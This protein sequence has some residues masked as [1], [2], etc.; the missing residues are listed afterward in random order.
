[1]RLH[2]TIGTGPNASCARYENTEYRSLSTRIVQSRVNEWTQDILWHIFFCRCAENSDV[3]YGCMASTSPGRTGQHSH[4]CTAQMQSGPRWEAKGVYRV[5]TLICLL[6][7]EMEYIIY[8]F[9]YSMPQLLS[10]SLSHPLSLRHQSPH[11]T[12]IAKWPIAPIGHR[13]LQSKQMPSVCCEPRIPTTIRTHTHPS[14]FEQW[15]THFNF[16]YKS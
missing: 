5:G 10:F 13:F 1:M 7:V 8:F 6:T 4:V 15:S 11:S 16:N 14:A 3:I 2:W 12:I 9:I